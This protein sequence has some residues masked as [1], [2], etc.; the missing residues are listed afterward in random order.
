[1][2][3]KTAHEKDLAILAR[4][5]LSKRIYGEIVELKNVSH[6]KYGTRY[7]ADVYLKDEHINAYMLKNK[8]AVPYD[9][10]TKKTDWSDF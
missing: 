10:K 4:D 9:G 5:A 1:M 3:A 6:D 8:Y 2:R 7:I